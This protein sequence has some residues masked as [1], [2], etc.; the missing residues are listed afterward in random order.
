MNDK[1]QLKKEV[2]AILG[3]SD[4]YDLRERSN[5]SKIKTYYET[6]A[7]LTTSVGR[8]YLERLNA[9][10]AGETNCSCIIC[11]NNISDDGVIC[12]SC[13]NRLSSGKRTIYC[14]RE[15][16]EQ[17]SD[18]ENDQ[19]NENAVSV[20]DR[21]DN[22]KRG[23][24]TNLHKVI[25]VCISALLIVMSFFAGKYVGENY[26][27]KNTDSSDT[28]A[29][30]NKYT[31]DFANVEQSLNSSPTDENNNSTDDKRQFW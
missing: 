2:S 1:E 5:V 14:N 17:K 8:K 13:M 19:K 11:K 22:K 7:S 18:S 3:I 24:V 28:D 6:K 31:D 10:E 21:S 25:T 12:S 23:K 30:N 20:K 26:S 15:K 9:L 16:D 4:K 27:D 29:I